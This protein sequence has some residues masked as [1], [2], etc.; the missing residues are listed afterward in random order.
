MIYGHARALGPKRSANAPI[1]YY[2]MLGA[3]NLSHREC[4]WVRASSAARAVHAAPDIFMRPR[5]RIAGE[6]NHKKS[7]V[8]IKYAHLHNRVFLI[9]RLRMQTV[10]LY[11]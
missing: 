2:Y 4:C 6:T 7:T 5:A 1:H 3:E 11:G 8:F 9:E 10:I